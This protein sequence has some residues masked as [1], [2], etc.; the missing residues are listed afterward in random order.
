MNKKNLIKSIVAVA[1]LVVVSM[2]GFKTAYGYGG[3]GGGVV[4]NTPCS[5]VTYADWQS[6]TNGMQYRNIVGQSPA[7]CTL[8]A[9]QQLNRSKS[10]ETSETPKEENPGQVL[11]EKIYADG[12]LLRGSDKKVYLVVGK[13]LKHIVTLAELRK[14]AG[15][16]IND[17]SNSVIKSYGTVAVLGEKKYG[18]GQLIRNNNVKVYVIVNGKKKHILNLSELAKYYFGKPIY[19]VS[20]EDLDLYPNF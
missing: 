18:E 11:G 4:F 20:A 7:N 16:K 3:G 5:S 19:H 6:C 15:K 8:T 9:S 10:C 12:S 13:N 1:C 14:Y 2:F 17:V